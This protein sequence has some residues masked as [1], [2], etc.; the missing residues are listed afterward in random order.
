MRKVP[1]GSEHSICKESLDEQV[2]SVALAT[3]G[4]RREYSER[5]RRENEDGEE[6]RK[7]NCIT[8]DTLCVAC[9]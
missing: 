2:P 9:S 5:K 3:D 1:I 8:R 6:E 7:C 4:R